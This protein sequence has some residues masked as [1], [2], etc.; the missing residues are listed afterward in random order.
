MNTGRCSPGLTQFA[1]LDANDTE[2]LAPRDERALLQELGECKRKLAHALA[3]IEGID[4]P[5]DAEPRATAHYIAAAYS[6][7]GPEQARLGAVYRRYS[8]LRSKLALA[9]LKLVAHVAKRFRER[10]LPYSDLMQEGF[11]GLLEA[12][13]R[14]D[15]VHQTKLATYATWW[16]RQ[17][18]Q[19]A[20]ASGAYAVRLTPRHLRQLAHNQLSEQHLQIGPGEAASSPHR[21]PPRNEMIDRIYSATQ[22]TISLDASYESGSSFRLIETMSDP[23]GDRTIDVDMQETIEKLMEILRPREQ[24]V[25]ALRFGLGGHERLSLTQVGKILEVSKE[26]VRQIEERALQKLRASTPEPQSAAGDLTIGC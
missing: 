12:I 22:P 18:I 2:L 25:I 7:N 8:E 20:V 11:C 17:S 13:D 19:R 23:D 24:H 26:R 15:L 3:G 10:G 1:K 6:G 14:F 21:D 9:N 16:I 4:V 5:A